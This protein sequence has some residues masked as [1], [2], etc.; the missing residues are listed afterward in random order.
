MEILSVRLTAVNPTSRPQILHI[1]ARPNQHH[2]IGRSNFSTG[3]DTIISRR[4]ARFTINAE[5]TPERLL[6]NNLSLIN[7]V[8]VN[9]TP[10]LPF[11]WQT[12]YDGDEIVSSPLFGIY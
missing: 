7:G 12:L 2:T 11:Q 6:V 4:H 9:F 3:D 8:L 1:P 10:V 5:T